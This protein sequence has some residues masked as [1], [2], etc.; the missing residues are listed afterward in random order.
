AEIIFP[1]HCPVCGADIE[2]IEGEAIARCR[3]GLICAAQRNE[4]IKHFAS[5]KALDID[6]LG[7]KIIEQ[8]VDAQLVK[9]PADLVALTYGDLLTLERMGDK[10]ATKLLASIDQARA[11]T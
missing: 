1:N 2:R 3:G 7:T 9:T 5:R 8:F 10:S 4:A 11:T 6:G